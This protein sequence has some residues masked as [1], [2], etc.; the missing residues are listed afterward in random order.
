LKRTRKA[1]K[2]GL[3]ATTKHDV[4]LLFDWT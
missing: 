1:D 3:T 4:R 2:F